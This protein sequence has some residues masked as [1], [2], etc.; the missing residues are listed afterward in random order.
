MSFAGCIYCSISYS[1]FDGMIRPGAEG[2][3]IYL[4]LAQQIKLCMTGL[5][6]SLSAHFLE[7]TESMLRS[8]LH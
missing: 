2:H 3:A 4:G 5:K 8:Q 6:A 7:V 1:Y